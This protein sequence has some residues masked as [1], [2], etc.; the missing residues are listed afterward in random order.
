MLEKSLE[1]FRAW[2]RVTDPLSDPFPKGPTAF[3]RRDPGSIGPI[4]EFACVK[5]VIGLVEQHAEQRAPG[6]CRT[7]HKNNLGH[8]CPL[9]GRDC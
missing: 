6:S 1:A 3:D 8:C 9:S 4:R 7:H 2:I 5:H